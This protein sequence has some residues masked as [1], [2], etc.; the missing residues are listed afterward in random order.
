MSACS[1]QN[2]LLNFTWM[3]PDHHAH[4]Y[5]EDNGHRPPE[6]MYSTPQEFTCYK[7]LSSLNKL[8]MDTRVIENR[9]NRLFGPLEAHYTEP[10]MSQAEEYPQPNVAYGARDFQ[11]ALHDFSSARRGEEKMVETTLQSVVD[12]GANSQH[13]DAIDDILRTGSHVGGEPLELVH[14]HSVN[15]VDKTT[16]TMARDEE[17]L[18]GTAGTKEDGKIDV[19]NEFEVVRPDDTDSNNQEVYM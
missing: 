19:E 10:P 17:V 12:N 11:Q 6:T 18:G 8:P 9:D 1:F 14:E 3:T 15:N 16:E 13:L 2:S 5:C 4:Q 7:P